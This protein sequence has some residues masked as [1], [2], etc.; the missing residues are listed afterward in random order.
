M[1]TRYQSEGVDWYDV[2]SPTSE[3]I[4]S[5]AKTCGLP[6]SFLPDLVVVNPQVS[7]QSEKGALKLTLNFP[8]VKRTDMSKPHQIKFIATKKHLITIRFEDMQVFDSFIKDF[9]V[10]T[11][12][13]KGEQNLT[14]GHLLC[15]LLLRFYRNLDFKLDYLSN[16]MNDIDTEI[17]NGHEREMVLDIADAGRR[18]IAFRQAIESQEYVL[19]N[20]FRT[21]DN[22]F[23]KTHKPDVLRINEQYIHI[24]RRLSRSTIAL[25]EL[26]ETNN[27]LITT[28]QNEIMKNLT[29]MA[30]VCF[31]LSLVSSIFG[32]N[33]V[34]TPI[35]GKPGDFWIII[36]FML[37]GFICFFIFFWRKRWL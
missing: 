1:I 13:R 29:I 20:L 11:I 19:D 9:E 28:R 26:R 21:I 14:A 18:L 10:I 36:G 2:L 37:F 22:A 6:P 34:G 5:L 4:R 3:E 31:P 17:F 35:L 24:V 23:G 8:V 7:T 27:S 16:R 12:L 32:M 25:Q 33:T 30:F 15:M